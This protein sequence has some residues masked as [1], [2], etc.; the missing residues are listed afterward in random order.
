VITDLSVTSRRAIPKP[1]SRCHGSAR[2]GRNHGA[3]GCPGEFLQHSPHCP[4]RGPA[5]TWSH[6]LKTHENRQT[7]KRDVEAPTESGNWP[8]VAGVLSR[9]CFGGVCAARDRRQI[10]GIPAP[11]LLRETRAQGDVGA[12][13]SGRVAPLGG[14]SMQDFS[15]GALANPDRRHYL[16]VPFE[17]FHASRPSAPQMPLP[18]AKTLAAAMGAG[19]E[20]M[21][22]SPSIFCHNDLTRTVDNGGVR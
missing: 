4:L 14:I 7:G 5:R 18:T 15:R 2:R 16:R 17:T 9:R 21:S 6:S 1:F 8:V 20:T 13:D 10:L 11:C 19:V 12:G 22:R 3:G